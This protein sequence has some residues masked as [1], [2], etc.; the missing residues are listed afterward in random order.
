MHQSLHQL[1][2]QLG[3]Y[4]LRIL[5]KV[6]LHHPSVET[7]ILTQHL[8]Y[9]SASVLAKVENFLALCVINNTTSE[10]HII[11]TARIFRE[12]VDIAQQVGIAL[13][14][15]EQYLIGSTR[16]GKS[17]V[18]ILQ[19]LVTVELVSRRQIARFALKEDALNV[20]QLGFV[21]IKIY[22]CTQE[23]FNQ[24]G[25]LKRIGIIPRNITAREDLR[26][27][28]SIFLEGGTVFHFLIC[29]SRNG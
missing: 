6:S 18:S 26:Q 15:R 4:L 28:R 20:H 9:G 13:Q 25:H 7:R 29:D 27:L 19:I 17:A 12:E 5:R 3:K 24:Q 2:T 10:V 14:L 16:V 11:I 1:Q 23:F 21:Y 22:S 8:K